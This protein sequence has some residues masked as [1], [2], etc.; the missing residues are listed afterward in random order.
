MHSRLHSSLIR[1][2]VLYLKAPYLI[3][4]T[5]AYMVVTQSFHTVV[6]G[7]NLNIVNIFLVAFL[8]CS[9]SPVA[10]PLAPTSCNSTVTLITSPTTNN[11]PLSPTNSHQTQPVTHPTTQCQSVNSSITRSHSQSTCPLTQTSSQRHVHD[12]H[13]LIPSTN[14]AHSNAHH[15]LK[16]IFGHPVL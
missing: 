4:G 3:T 5:V 7:S 10:Y 1:H 13:S 8:R 11:Q 6:T 15:R 9:S 2:R 16:I 12:T 14:I